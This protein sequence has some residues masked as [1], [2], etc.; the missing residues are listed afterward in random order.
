M[1][2][3]VRTPYDDGSDKVVYIAVAKISNLVAREIINGVKGHFRMYETKGRKVT[4][5]ELDEGQS[6]GREGF[7]LFLYK[8]TVLVP[9]SY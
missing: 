8:G 2:Y 3:T 5:Y 9:E 6:L 4:A 7:M 1:S